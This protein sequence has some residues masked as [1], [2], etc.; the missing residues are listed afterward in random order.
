MVLSQLPIWVSTGRVEIAQ[1]RPAQAIGLPVPGEDAF[2]HPLRL[3][4]RVYRSLDVL[5]ANGN[6]C[7]STV[8]RAAGRK[9]NVLY[10]RIRHCVQQPERVGHIVAK[11]LPRALHGLSHVGE[12]GKVDNGLN[13]MR[14]DEFAN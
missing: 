14:F 8:G 9:H 1:G 13:S 11:I 6:A 12:P 4:I 5:L 7:W 10:P 3:T 2:N